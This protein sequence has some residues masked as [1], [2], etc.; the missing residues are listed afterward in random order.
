MIV[1]LLNFNTNL[2]PLFSINRNNNYNKPAIITTPKD[3]VSISF[4][5]KPESLDLEPA[6]N[7]SGIHCPGCGVCMLSQKDFEKILNTSQRI[8]TAKDFIAVLNRNRNYIPHFMKDILSTYG[9]LE[10]NDN[11]GV[12]D[13][14]RIKRHE[15]YKKKEK[16]LDIVKKY[17]INS[18][19]N[20]TPEKQEKLKKLL[21]E[22][23]VTTPYNDYKAKMTNILS[24]LDADAEFKENINTMAFRDIVRSSLYYGAF[25]IKGYSNLSNQE[26]ARKLLERIFSPSVNRITKIQDYEPF[27]NSANNSVMICDS[28][29]K[30][31]SKHIFW[32]SP[33]NPELKED[34]ML[35]LQDLSVMMGNGKLSEN[36]AYLKNF[37]FVTNLLSRNFIS[38]SNEDIAKI[39]KLK[40]IASR[41]EEFA[42]I[43]QTKI[44]VPCAECGADML[45]HSIRLSIEHDMKKCSTPN[46]YG[47]L[48]DRY[49]PYIGTYAK[50]FSQIYKEIIQENPNISIDEFVETYTQI[51]EKYLDNCVKEAVDKYKSKRVFYLSYPK[52]L[53]WY[54]RILKSVENYLNE[55]NFKDYNFGNLHAACFEN[56]DFKEA[57]MKAFYALL[58]DFRTI[59]YK[60]T[61]V[62]FPEIEY[63]T[64][65]DK[66]YTLMFNLFKSDVATVD[67]LVPMSKGGEKSKDN[68]IA[69]CKGCNTIKSNKNVKSWFF[70]DYNIRKNLKKQLD[71]IDKLAKEGHI[72]GYDDWA[73]D[74]AKNINTLTDGAFYYKDEV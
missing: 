64:D 44:P 51:T 42:P 36:D 59:A 9:Q 14:I 56:V 13:Y 24:F 2:K 37:T 54:D 70:S 26:L 41:H 58:K 12:G 40:Y 57:N 63:N 53:I 20:D 61:L 22:I 39:S 71:A 38:F 48:L 72:Q 19:K 29:D 35:Y 34:I 60:S 27:V 17:L 32:V 16:R 55:G 8:N 23:N 52:K 73:S 74:T 50:D 69:L 33:H 4:C 25:N 5:G 15:A 47:R 43:Q 46:Q 31:K 18:V 11:L 28:C 30:S 10:N 65:K 49:K 6:L 1:Q 67:H 62:H 3:S 45:P 21:D 66:V 68:L 7:Y